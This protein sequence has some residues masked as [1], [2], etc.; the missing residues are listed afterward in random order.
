MPCGTSYETRPAWE[1]PDGLIHPHSDGWR[2]APGAILTHRVTG[3]RSSTHPS[4]PITSHLYAHIPAIHPPPIASTQ[5]ILTTNPHPARRARTPHN[6]GSNDG[7]YPPGQRPSPWNHIPNLGSPI[8]TPRVLVGQA[9]RDAR[10]ATAPHDLPLRPDPRREGRAAKLA[11]VERLAEQC[12]MRA[13]LGVVAEDEW[14]DGT[15]PLGG[16]DLVAA[17]RTGSRR[18]ARE[19]LD[20]DRAATALEWLREF[21]QASGRSPF[22][23]LQHAGD[24][25]GSVYNSETLEMMAEYIRRRGSRQKGRIGT[26]ILSDTV[27]SYISAIRTMR[28]VEAHYAVT[29]AATN[30][31]LPAA[32]KRARQAQP[33]GTRQLRR[34][35]RASHLK[36]LAALGYDRKSARGVLEWAAA[37]VAWNLLLRGGELGVVTGKQFDTSRDATFGA[38]EF[39]TPCVDSDWLPWLTW[40][41]VPIKD[42]A[43]RLRVC[44][45]A[46]RRRGH[47]P[48]GSDPLCVYDAIVM[49]W[50]SRTFQHPPHVGRA[51]G[52]LAL[53]PF[54]TGPK[55]LPWTTD[56]TRR[57]A[58]GMAT[59]LG[60]HP[61]E[62][63]GKSFRIGGATDWRDVFVTSSA[64]T[65][66]VSSLSA[67]GGTPTSRS[68]TSGRSP[69][70]TS[71]GQQRW[72][73]HRAPIL[74]HFAEAGHSQRTSDDLIHPATTPSSTST[75]SSIHHQPSSVS[76]SVARDGLCWASAWEGRASMRRA[77]SV[78][79]RAAWVSWLPPHSRA[80]R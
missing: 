74:S 33:P 67:G 76:E 22:I 78:A 32:S 71:A 53:H 77:T 13:N 56:D 60:L 70:P 14:L 6:A 72:L 42:V 24:L 54:F 12:G 62:F 28:G 20:L 26:P 79:P 40:D 5:P 63:G 59:A 23:P 51:T 3:I 50:R 16:T 30:V 39:R 27:D 35:I 43:A 34:G 9:Q 36:Q 73:T 52:A 66:S 31:I 38:I 2:S 57:L 61:S 18:R 45:M 37:L 47:G 8:S 11:R 69:A 17:L 64:R 29:L 1:S 25:K 4:T 15:P 46:V 65:P 75:S 41:V 49:A 10:A 7:T 80:Q 48:A 55:G 19:T 58:A 21:V 44:P 68:Y